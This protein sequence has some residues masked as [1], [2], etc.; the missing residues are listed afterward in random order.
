MMNKEVY[1]VNDEENF[2]EEFNK[3]KEQYFQDFRNCALYS[4]QKKSCKLYNN[5]KGN[6]Y[7]KEKG[8]ESAGAQGEYSLVTVNNF[9]SILKTLLIIV[10]GNTP[11]FKSS[12]TNNDSKSIDQSRLAEDIITYYVAE[13]GLEDIWTTV[14]EYAIVLGEG[15]LKVS[16][17]PSSGNEYDIEEGDTL[18]NEEGEQRNM[19]YEGDLAFDVVSPFDIVWDR[20]IKDFKKAKWCAV[21]SQENRWDL[22]ARYPDAKD[23]ILEV[24]TQDKDTELIDDDFSVLL[25][26]SSFKSKENTE[27]VPV[28][29]FFH[30]KSDAVPEGRYVK[31]VG[32][33]VLIDM[34]LPYCEMPVK[35][36]IAG[37]TLL[38]G[39]GY[40]T[41]FDLIGL[42][43][44]MNCALSTITSQVRRDAMAN[45]W[46]PGNEEVKVENLKGGGRAIRTKGTVPP[47]LIDTNVNLQQYY[48]ILKACNQLSEMISGINAT[49]RGQID[50]KLSGTAYALL[51]SKSLQ[52]ANDV[53]RNYYKLLEDSA[54]FSIRVVRDFSNTQRVVSIVGQD[55]R[56][57]TEVSFTSDDL[58]NFTRFRISSQN[59][60]F[61]STA[62]KM[63]IADKLLSV[64]GPTNGIQPQEYVTLIETGQLD[65]LYDGAMKEITKVR[66]ENEF[67]LRGK[68]VMAQRYENHPLHIAEHQQ[69]TSD[70]IIMRNPEF[71]QKVYAHIIHHRQ[72]WDLMSVSEP[73]VL[74]ALGTAPSIGAQSVQPPPE[75]PGEAPTAQ[76]DVTEM[77]RPVNEAP[78]VEVKPVNLPSPPIPPITQ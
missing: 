57:I 63:E 53:V 11:C 61:K 5:I 23:E 7:L 56:G 55:K 18:G 62:G 70:P 38:T 31:M 54:T 37:R 64:F 30:I 16:W 13:K 60:I 17:D 35:Q 44:V 29:E 43:E 32:N 20:S 40:A 39:Y 78:E 8:I 6:T 68:D 65:P 21:K 27:L 73:Q 42:Q 77:M 71:L 74:Q 9:R 75:L 50:E 52:F 22:V 4:W 72:V 76:G 12:P 15:Y 3:R 66:R 48:D 67:L 34:P 28:W 49:T 1:W 36:M 47:Q 45:W 14:A 19:S 26:A 24:A 51:D 58:Q 33:V 46:I 10:T 41:A 69:L 59:P 2:T 25:E